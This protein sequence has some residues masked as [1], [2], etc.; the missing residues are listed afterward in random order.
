MAYKHNVKPRMNLS[1]AQREIALERAMNKGQQAPAPQ[2]NLAQ[3]LGAARMPEMPMMPS[4][5]PQAPMMPP[6]MQPETLGEP[7][8]AMPMELSDV[9]ELS[10]YALIADQLWK[11]SGGNGSVGARVWQTFLDESGSQ[12]LDSPRDYFISSY[13]RW[14]VDPEKFRKQKPREA[15][16]IRQLDQEFKASVEGM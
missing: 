13:L 9:E 1:K 8:Q 14:K 15:R 10:Q 7:E 3:S 11:D 4:E 12:H 16:L 6:P 2:G 5:E